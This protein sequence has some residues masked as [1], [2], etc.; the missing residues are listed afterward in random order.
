MLA[1]YGEEDAGAPGA[2]P[3]SSEYTQEQRDEDAARVRQALREHGYTAARVQGTFGYAPPNA[4][5]PTPGPF[6]LRKRID[7]RSAAALPSHPPASGYE[8][9]VRLFLIGVCLEGDLVQ[10]QLGPECVQAMTRLGLLAASPLDPSQILSYV[11]LYPLSL[12]PALSAAG[13]GGKAVGSEGDLILATDWPPP[14]SCALEEEPVMYIGSDSL[15]LVRKAAVCLSLLALQPRT[16]SR[17]HALPDTDQG[18]RQGEGHG[19]APSRRLLDLCTGS[20][21]QGLALARICLLQNLPVQVP[22]RCIPPR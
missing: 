16:S 4:S 17:A 18:A 9:L 14:V 7:H 20:G 10:Q 12:A 11:Q 21:V 5:A 13:L 3:G 6:Y 1:A 22:L 2:R 15:G 8:V 19:G